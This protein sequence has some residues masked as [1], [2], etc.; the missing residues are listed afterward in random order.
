MGS[1]EKRLKALEEGWNNRARDEEEEREQRI[2]RTIT[3]LVV[4]EHARL[5]KSGESGDL[6]EKACL[7]VAFDQYDHLGEEQRE[8]I[9]RGWAENM[10]GWGPIDWGIATGKL[11]PPEG[12]R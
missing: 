9:G 7:T 5:R 8:Y 3:R 10:R 4:A 11:S 12:W 2:L 6:I 1:V